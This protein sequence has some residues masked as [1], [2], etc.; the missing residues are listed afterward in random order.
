MIT[1]KLDSFS[2]SFIHLNY[3]LTIQKQ[4]LVEKDTVGH[5]FTLDFIIVE[6]SITSTEHTC[7]GPT[8]T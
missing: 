3:I 7:K 6:P 5:Q 8:R 1:L 2:I 4:N